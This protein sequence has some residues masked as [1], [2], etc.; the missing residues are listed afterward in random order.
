MVDDP[1]KNTIALEY[2]VFEGDKRWKATVKELIDLA[3]TDLSALGLYKIG[4]VRDG[5]VLRSDK[6]YPIYDFPYQKRLAV[7]REFVDGFDNLVCVGRAGQFRYN[8]M[9]HSVMTGLL[10]ARKL[11]G[12]KVD[13]WAVNEDALYHE[14]TEP[15]TGDA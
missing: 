15:E 5:L 11:L 12:E 13:P 6:A 10:G 1:S 8:N 7:I 9:D 2:F 14:E 3:K 4:M